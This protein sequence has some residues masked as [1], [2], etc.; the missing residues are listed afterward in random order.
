MLA[1]PLI[2]LARQRDALAATLALALA[3]CAAPPPQGYGVAAPS[4][5]ALAQQQMEEAQ[6]S[7]QVDQQRTYLNLIGQMQKANQWYASLAH[8]EAFERQYGSNAQIRLLR[9]DALRNTN[10]GPQAEQAYKTLLN[11]ADTTTVARARRGLGLLYAS[12]GQFAQAVAQLE[13]ARQL[14]PIDADLLSDLAYAHMLDGQLAPAQLPIMQA[15]QLAPDNARV[16]LN[17]ALFWLVNG[18]QA[19]AGQLLRRLSQPQAKNAPP[20]IDE[21]SLRTL[22]TQRAAVEQ[23]LQARAH[24]TAMPAPTAQAPALAAPAPV[25]SAPRVTA[26]VMRT[27]VLGPMAPASQPA[28]AVPAMPPPAPDAAA[29]EPTQ[30]QDGAPEQRPPQPLS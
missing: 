28:R 13:L 10:Q 24:A 14:T 16:Q 6:Q 5:A 27:I 8:T 12:Q 19:Q 3:G 30:A 18:Q 7:T 26:P 22:H 20:L 2:P 4:T 15:A 11:D 9:A 21:H 17:L 29:A 1:R 23:A 25:A